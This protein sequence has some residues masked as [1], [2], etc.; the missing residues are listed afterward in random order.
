MA[1]DFDFERGQS[2]GEWLNQEMHEACA[3]EEASWALERLR[4]VEERL[5]AGRLPENRLITQ[6]P[7]MEEF[8]AFT[9]P[10]RYI[11]FGRRL[12]EICTTVIRESVL[13]IEMVPSFAAL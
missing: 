5:Q 12:Y 4:L 7:W 1:C 6:I 9:A 10:G 8:S 3:F 11:Y 13:A 2:F